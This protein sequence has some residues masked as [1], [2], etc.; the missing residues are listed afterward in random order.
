MTLVLGLSAIAAGGMCVMLVRMRA[1]PGASLLAVC[2]AAAAVWLV[3]GAVQI[4]TADV[5]LRRLTITVGFSCAVAIV[6]TAWRAVVLRAPWPWR[7]PAVVARAVAVPMIGTVVLAA[8]TDA[9]GPFYRTLDITADTQPIHADP[10]PWMVAYL[11]WA[12]GLVVWGVAGLIWLVLHAPHGRRRHRWMS[13]AAVAVPVCV[14]LT[15]TAWRPGGQDLTPVAALLAIAGLLWLVWRMKLLDIDVGLLPVARDVVVESM[16]EGVVVV[17]RHG[18]VADLNPAAAGLLGVVPGA[19][20]AA[21]V[22]RVVPGWRDD[23][24][25]RSWEFTTPGRLPARTVE[26]RAGTLRDGGSGRLVLLRDVTEQRTARAALELSLARHE[27][28]SRHDALTGLPNRVPL[29]S[30]LRLALADPRGVTLLI[31]DLDGFKALNDTFGHR[32]GDRVLRELATRLQHVM[33]RDAMV[34]RLAG[35]EFAVV[36]GG[37][38]PVAAGAAAQR[39]LGAMYA[40]FTVGETEVSL[41]ASIGVAFGPRHG[42]DADEL[43]HAADV[44]MYHAKRTAARWAV[45]EPDLD[46]R[47]PERLILRHE[48]RRALSEHELALHYQPQATP[49]GRVTA[50]EALVRW[51]HPQRG[52]LAP[53]A[54]LP[55]TEDTEL[56]CRL[57]DEVLDIALGDVAAWTADAPG[58]SVSV[59]LSSLDIRDPAL[60]DRIAAAIGRHGVDPRRL[61]LEVTENA[62]VAAGD[63]LTRLEQVRDLGVRVSLD[64]FGTGVGPLATLRELPVDEL[65]IDRSFVASMDRPR[66]AALVGGLIRL[67]HDLGLTVVAEGVE[68]PECMIAL[69]DMGCDLLQGHHL[70]HP[71]PLAPG[72]RTPAGLATA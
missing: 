59:N 20:V 54:F 57:T 46:G 68:T 62:L 72:T 30:R 23:D 69:R 16:S 53:G 11:I 64:D 40:P 37:G 42:A 10:G 17:D 3:A 27:H 55:V 45:Y 58:L 43:V 33:D 65:K 1:E 71:E 19:V 8:A 36:L 5:D 63:G 70:G 51:H 47:R 41:A 24:D 66:E 44:A 67:G 4:N 29:F 60:P 7:V 31:L 28:A 34:A 52:L 48:L 13:I 49:D 2:T 22:D 32:S 39:L 9:G 21:A 15:V 14:N 18:R 25:R 6:Y 61:T 35:D 12:Y 38:D 50:V 56:I 26:V